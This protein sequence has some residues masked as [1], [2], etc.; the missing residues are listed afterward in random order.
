MNET[1]YFLC[2]A[3]NF[4]R[5]HLYICQDREIRANLIEKHKYILTKI[6]LGHLS[7]AQNRIKLNLFLPQC[8]EL[9]S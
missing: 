1:I 2:Q 7:I 3:L 5:T 9:D 4:I 6:Y 8:H